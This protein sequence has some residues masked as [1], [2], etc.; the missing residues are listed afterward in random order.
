VRA[1]VWAPLAHRVDLVVREGGE[2]ALHARA[3]GWWEDDR[4]LTTGDRYG[5]RLD[6]DDEVLYDPRGRSLPDGVHGLSEV[7]DTAPLSAAGWAGLALG[8]SAGV[9]G[10]IYELHLG[11]FTDGGTLDSAIERLD[12]LVDLGVSFVELLP[13][14]AFNGADNWGYDGVAWFA[15]Q[16]SYGGPAAY[17]RFV[18]A[19]HERGLA[20]IQDVVYNH[21]GPSGNVLPRFGPYLRHDAGNTWG[22]A[23]D[24]T[25]P[26]VRRYI[27][28]NARM[29]LEEYGVDGLRLDAVHA[30]VDTG[31]V[32]LLTELAAQIDALSTRLGRPL[33]VIAESDLNDPIM[34]EPR[35]Q[36]GH[37]LAAQ[38]SDDYHHAVHVA[39]TGE[40]D[41]YYADFASLGALAKAA[42]KGFFHDGSYSSFRGRDHG[43]PIPPEVPTRSLVTFAQDHDQIGN[44]ATGDRLSAT[45]S[46]ARLRVAAAL[47]LGSPFTPMLFMG[48]E[49]GASTPWQFFT[50]H[51]EPEL[52]EA[53]ARGRIEEFAR[54]GWDPATVP[55]PQDPATVARSHLDWS[56]LG[57]S[58]HRELWAFTRELI[59]LRAR[60]PEFADHDFRMLSADGSDEYGWFVLRQGALELRVNL[61]GADWDSEGPVTVLLGTD[62]LIRAT[63]GGL[64]LPPDSAAIVRRPAD[65][66]HS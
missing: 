5:F 50:S 12:H 63:D 42:T 38:W 33:T 19:A 57:R 13:V 46:P 20:V 53:V 51:P 65:R 48:E 31:P 59:A 14:N 22:D 58:P 16:H 49:W 11:T 36:G 40:T 35:D 29:W 34:I 3:G 27:L 41:G 4:E 6:D 10:V 62:P 52:G 9:S 21:L 66:S 26:E 18:S 56:E 28:D 23:I 44:R 32:H 64:I 24:L 60:E 1:R 30:L 25:Q 2:R 54:M 43:S 45:L 61:G 15:V 39:L 47:S 37:G 8:T 17:R 55:D 7:V